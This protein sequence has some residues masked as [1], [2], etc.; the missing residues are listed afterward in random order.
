MRGLWNWSKLEESDR[1]LTAIRVRVLGNCSY[2]REEY[3]SHDWE[4][5]REG[6]QLTISRV[7]SHLLS[8]DV[9]P[10]N[11]HHES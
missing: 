11:R 3:R 6:W 8:Y 9:V 1:E 4:R 2:C 10:T 5:E 7:P